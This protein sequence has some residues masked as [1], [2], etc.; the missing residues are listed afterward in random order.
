M[1]WVADALGKCQF[2]VDTHEEIRDQL[3]GQIPTSCPDLEMQLARWGDVGRKDTGKQAETYSFN[4][5]TMWRAWKLS[6]ASPD[7]E[8]R[9]TNWKKKKM[10]KSQV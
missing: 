9:W 7:Q 8:K 10:M 4:S 3:Q 1:H 5:D 2:V 6:L